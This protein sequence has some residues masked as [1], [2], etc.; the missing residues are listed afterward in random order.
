MSQVLNLKLLA[1]PYILSQNCY[2]VTE[3]GVVPSPTQG[4]LPL[5]NTHLLHKAFCPLELNVERSCSDQTF[6]LAIF[7]FIPFLFLYLFLDENVFLA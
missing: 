2:P 7:V 1:N 6:F 5:L 3:I 4:L